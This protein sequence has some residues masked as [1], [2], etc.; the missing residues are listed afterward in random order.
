MGRKGRTVVKT[1]FFLLF[2]S[3]VSDSI[4]KEEAVWKYISIPFG[5]LFPVDGSS[6]PSHKVL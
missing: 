5:K 6:S 2:V 1:G 3:V 4:G